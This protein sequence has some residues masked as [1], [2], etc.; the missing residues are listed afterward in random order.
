MTSNHR[1]LM[2]IKDVLTQIELN[3]DIQTADICITPLGD[4]TQSDE[5]DVNEDIQ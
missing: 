5:D 4:G 3:E 2:T 1:N